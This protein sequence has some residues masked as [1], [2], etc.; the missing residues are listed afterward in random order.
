MKSK[1]QSKL[2]KRPGISTVTGKPKRKYT[3]S[4]KDTLR[5]GSEGEPNVPD[6]YGTK[7]LVKPASM[8]VINERLAFLVEAVADIRA[9]LIEQ[10]TTLKEVR[11]LAYNEPQKLKRSEPED[12][13]QVTPL[14]EVKQTTQ[15]A[16]PLV[17]LDDVRKA[18]LAAVSAGQ[19]EAVISILGSL[20]VGK[21]SDLKVTDYATFLAR[22]S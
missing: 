22:L 18:A 16:L 6:T 13:P 17:T 12:F 4:A 9:I 7:V 1:T 3:R 2:S 21:V 14:G 20:G 15:P 11:A 8:E 19:R 10:A 5:T